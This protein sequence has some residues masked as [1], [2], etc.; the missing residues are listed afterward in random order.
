MKKKSPNQF[1][2]RIRTLLK[3]FSHPVFIFVTL[4]VVWIAITL[5]WVIWFLDSAQEIKKLSEDLGHP[6]LNNHYTLVI[7]VVGCILLGVILLGTV[8]LFVK[9]QQQSNLM[10]QQ[11]SFVSSVTHELRSPL[12]SLQLTFETM[13]ARTLDTSTSRKL[14]DMASEDT[15]RLTRLV[16]QILVSSRLDRGIYGIE[17]KSENIYFYDFLQ[18]TDNLFWQLFAI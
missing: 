7:L 17:D 5:I 13:R 11:K 9:T 3:W 8:I 16:D 15:Q 6:H 2:F 12:A 4:Q 18:K 1:R 10:N 14:L